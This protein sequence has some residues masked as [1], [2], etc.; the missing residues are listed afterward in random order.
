MSARR[1]PRSAGSVISCA[2]CK[3][4]S[5]TGQI[6]VGL[7]RAWLLKEQGWSLATKTVLN[8]DRE[9]TIRQ[10]DDLCPA[11]GEKDRLTA[12]WHEFMAQRIAKRETERK[13]LRGKRPNS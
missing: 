5:T 2:G 8:A 3:I 6:I 7:H 13:S 11:C 4:T 9:I 12:E 1:L 10:G